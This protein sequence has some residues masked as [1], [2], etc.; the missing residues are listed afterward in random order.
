MTA[1]F[2]ADPHIGH[3]NI[4]S[5]EDRPFSSVGQMDEAILGYWS[6]LQAGDRFYIL[7]DISL[8]RRYVEGALDRIPQG[9]QTFFVYGNHDYGFRNAV[10]GH[11]RIV[12]SGDMKEI[13][14]DGQR[15]V[16]CHYAMRSWPSSQ[17][18]SWQLH[19]HSHNRLH[20]W[21]RQLDVGV[22]SA[23]KLV[24]EY[25]PLS[26]EEVSRFIHDGENPKTLA[27]RFGISP[28]WMGGDHHESRSGCLDRR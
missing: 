28:S 12:W 3:V 26:F 7:G 16:L 20:P 24:G 17:H 15:I 19:G 8:H 2:T 5:H 10:D 6:K 18:G 14:V 21:E 4:L 1:W 9:V 13:K 11:P 22:D 25:R 27:D 23:A